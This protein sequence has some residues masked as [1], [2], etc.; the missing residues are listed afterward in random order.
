MT[1]RPN[2]VPDVIRGGR[3]GY[4]GGLALTPAEVEVS[5]AEIVVTCGPRRWSLRRDDSVELVGMQRTWV[6]KFHWLSD[7]RLSREYVYFALPGDVT[8]IKTALAVAG[9]QT[10]SRRWKS[11]RW[12]SD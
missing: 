1:P 10:S 7:G 12:G 6:W 11:F 8:R 4:L 9:W 3:L 5:S 2:D